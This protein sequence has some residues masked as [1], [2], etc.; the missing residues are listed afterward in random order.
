MAVEIAFEQDSTVPL[1]YIN[2]AVKAGSVTDPAGASGL[3]NFLGET[4]LRGTKSRTKEQLDLALDQMGAT[5]EV[6]T[7]AEALIFRGAVLAAQLE[8]F[9]SLVAEVITQPSFPET[10]IRK[11]KAELT[12]A[13]LE[14]LGHDSSL[15]SRR[16][17]QFLFQD[18]PYG[19]PVLGK[20]RDIQGLTVEKLQAHYD[21]LFQSNSLLV[22]GAGDALSGRIEEWAQ[23]MAATRPNRPLAAGKNEKGYFQVSRPL[24]GP[25][26]RLQIVDKPG[27]HSDDGSG[28]FSATP[29]QPRFWRRI[30]HRE[31]DDRG[32]S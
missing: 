16:F 29:G 23:D 24:D 13:I 15:A 12:S 14:E 26:R 6:E 2:V 5:L 27:R 1:V 11:L 32:P 7:R 18:H 28:F 3:T 8:P 19:K 30:I 10:E 31:D 25:S 21:K 20:T 4:M 9:L 22:V 17:N